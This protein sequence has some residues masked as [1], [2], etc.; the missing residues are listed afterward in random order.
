MNGKMRGTIY[1]LMAGLV[2]RA[3]FAPGKEPVAYLYNGVRLPKLPEWDKTAYPYAIIQYT[4]LGFGVEKWRLYLFPIEL[5]GKG[6]GAY[7]PHGMTY[8]WYNNEDTGWVYS[9]S[10]N[11]TEAAGGPTFEPLWTNHDILNEDGT[12]YLAASD[13]V[14][15]YE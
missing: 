11:H 7:F 2:S 10:A 1:G 14:P 8:C 9:A 4:D 12:I 15:V 3:E 5:V 6:N 13:P